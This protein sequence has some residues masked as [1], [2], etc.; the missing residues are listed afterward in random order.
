MHLRASDCADLGCES[1][2]RG[3]SDMESAPCPKMS[4]NVPSAKMHFS[5]SAGRRRNCD[6]PARDD[7]TSRAIN[8]FPLRELLKSAPG[9]TGSGAPIASH[10]ELFGRSLV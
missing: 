7:G 8:C 9:Q 5:P 1:I 2:G 3:G 6:F 10:V 4:P